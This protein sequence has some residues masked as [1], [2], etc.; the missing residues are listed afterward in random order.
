VS[1]LPYIVAA[2]AVAVGMPVFFSVEVLL[3]TR[4]ARRRLESLDTR[5]RLDQ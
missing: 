1:H 5:P 4:L 2:Y 3:R